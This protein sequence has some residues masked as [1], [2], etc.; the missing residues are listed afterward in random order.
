MKTEEKTAHMEILGGVTIVVPNKVTKKNDLF[1]ISYN[2]R[3]LS[4][5]GCATTALYIKKTSQFLI[6][7]GNHTEGYKELDT[8]EQAIEYFYSKIKQANPKSEHKRL[9]KEV[10]GKFDYI[11]GGY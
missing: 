8:L 3:S 5:Y 9:F 6:L 11:E 10:K 7:N 1:H 2:N 4:D